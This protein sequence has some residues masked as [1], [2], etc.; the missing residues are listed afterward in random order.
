[1]RSALNGIKS[2]K[3]FKKWVDSVKDNFQGI[4]KQKRAQKLK[5]KE[6]P[7][8]REITGHTKTEL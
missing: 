2:R 6:S 1:V 8:W 4:F 7:L 5:A 3:N